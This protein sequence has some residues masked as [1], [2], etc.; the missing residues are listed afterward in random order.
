MGYE[1]SISVPFGLPHTSVT[2]CP[3]LLR[4]VNLLQAPHP[5]RVAQTRRHGI[6]RRMRAAHRRN[7]E[8]RP[9]RSRYL[10][11]KHSKGITGRNANLEKKLNGF[12]RWR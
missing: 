7:E 5:N 6:R 9:D 4:P 3:D 2:L 12:S 10:P 1:C 8:C 11:H